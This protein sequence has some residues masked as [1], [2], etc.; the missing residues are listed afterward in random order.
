[1]GELKVKAKTTVDQIRFRIQGSFWS[2]LEKQVSSRQSSIP[3]QLAVQ[4]FSSP[5]E[6]LIRAFAHARVTK[7]NDFTFR[8]LKYI[9]STIQ[10]R[11][12]RVDSEISFKKKYS[13][14]LQIS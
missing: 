3:T 1:M 9:K 6:N 4:S 5:I 11:A 12:F 8:L 2:Q 10:Q 13:R 14:K 7:M